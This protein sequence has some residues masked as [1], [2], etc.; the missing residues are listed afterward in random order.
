M[1][2]GPGELWAH[3]HGPQGGDEVNVIRSGANYGWPVITLREE[4]RCRHV[5][6]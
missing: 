4:L 3:E 5:N 6:R 1:N 2:R